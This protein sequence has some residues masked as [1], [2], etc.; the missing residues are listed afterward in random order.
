MT[1]QNAVANEE[2]TGDPLVLTALLSRYCPSTITFSTTNEK[3]K[4]DGKQMNEI[5][6]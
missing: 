6:V 4:R 5:E 3:G 2:N 1:K